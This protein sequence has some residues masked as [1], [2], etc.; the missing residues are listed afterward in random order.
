MPLEDCLAAVNSWWVRVPINS[1]YLHWDDSD[2][3]P[4]PW[5][6]LNDNIFCDVARALGM[7]YTLAIIDRPDISELSMFQTDE[8]NLVQINNGKYI[9]NWGDGQVVN[10]NSVIPTEI[11]KSISS[12]NFQHVIR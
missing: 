3:W 7:L 8:D 1:R 5:E 4:T 10:I 11:R 12:K 9:L 2:R 6:L